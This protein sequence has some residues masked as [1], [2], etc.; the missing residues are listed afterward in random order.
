MPRPQPP[1]PDDDHSLGARIIRY[2]LKK[3]LGR[4]QFAESLSRIAPITAKSVQRWENEGMTPKDHQI[5]NEV[6]RLLQKNGL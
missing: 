2:R 6:I 3:N 5:Y 1:P 4:R